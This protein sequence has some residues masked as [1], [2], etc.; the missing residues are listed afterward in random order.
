MHDA[1]EGM[2]NIC[3]GYEYNGDRKTQRAD[4]E[5]MDFE[6]FDAEQTR[7]ADG[8]SSAK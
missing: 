6:I 7:C 5:C 1:I 2:V 4:L 3:D 8:D